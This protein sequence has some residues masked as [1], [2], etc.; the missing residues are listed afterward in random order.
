VAL[1]FPVESLPNA[2]LGLP[3]TAFHAGAGTHSN[4]LLLLLSSLAMG[5]L[6]GASF[7]LVRRLRRF[8]GPAQ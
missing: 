1:S 7:A 2:L 3:H 4:G 8:E 5:A 6:A